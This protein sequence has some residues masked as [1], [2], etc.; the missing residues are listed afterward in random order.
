MSL[1]C[2]T[3]KSSTSSELSIRQVNAGRHEARGL[4]DP[5]VAIARGVAQE[6]RAESR[7]ASLVEFIR[8]LWLREHGAPSIADELNEVPDAVKAHG[9]KFTR[10][11][12]QRILRRLQK[13]RLLKPM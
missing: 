4:D 5:G 12:M 11:T 3:S 13:A 1:A 2:T 10:G 6:R 7:A 9:M 8:P